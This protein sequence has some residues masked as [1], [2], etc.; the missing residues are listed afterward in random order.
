MFSKKSS[1]GIILLFCI[2]LLLSACSGEA[3]TANT[4]SE[5]TQTPAVD[6]K[7][8][9][10]NPGEK[11][12]FPVTSSL[13]EGPNEVLLVDA[14]IEKN[15]AEQL[16]K[17]IRD[18]GKKLTTV[19]ISHKD[20]DFYFGLSTIREAFP[21]VKI[22][23]TPATVEEIKATI[24]LKSDY[25]SPIL[26][27]N[28]PTALIVPDV[29]DGDKLTVDGE[30]VQVIGLDGSAPTHTVLWVP[31][32]KTILGGVPIYEN[33][34]VWMAD[35]QTPESRDQWREILERI[36]AL[37]PERVIPGHY[38]DKSSE[39]TSS[40]V[41]TRDYIAE[42][43]AAAK[44]AKNS[45]ELTAAMQKAYPDLKNTSDLEMGAQVIKGELSWP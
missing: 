22:V 14:Q 37:K 19:Y 36:L 18:T 35:N 42:F 21:D 28:A 32:K 17:M 26:K 15:N 31:S 44:Q 8:T 13:I 34:H 24:Q 9:P 5:G 39:D 23:A 41:F 30:T 45:A 38:L 27:E 20:P 12:L 10:F 16:V 43:E 25:W 11:G 2:T 29:L 40:I 3:S 7:I 1:I 6:L 4:A 33:L